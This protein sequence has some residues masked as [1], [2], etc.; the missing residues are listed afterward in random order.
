PINAPDFAKPV[1]PAQGNRNR[2]V[3][4]VTISQSKLERGSSDLLEK[5]M[6]RL[7]QAASFQPDIACLPELFSDSPPEPVS[8]PVSDRLSAWAREHSAYVIFGV[9]TTSNGR[10]FNSALF[11]DRKGQLVGQYNK[12]H[13]T[14]GEL[15]EGTKPG[16]VEP[17]VFETDFGTIGIQICFDVNWWE[18][19]KRLKQKGAKIVFFPSAYPAARQLSALALMNQY[20]VVSSSMTRS[21]KIYDISGEVLGSSG[22]YQQW[23]GAVLPLG[24][25]LFEIDYHIDKVRE[26]QKKYLSKFEVT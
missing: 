11:M 7:D 24:K 22:E 6:A 5:T 14:E 8:G 12:M 25:R 18:M 3:R 23:A 20:Y 17:A 2:M 10:I 4:V 16:E 13:P 19:W 26:I 15:R 9:K 21:S 1:M